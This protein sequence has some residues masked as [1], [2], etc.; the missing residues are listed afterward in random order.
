MSNYMRPIAVFFAFL[1]VIFFMLAPVVS[2]NQIAL[3]GYSSTESEIINGGVLM[4]I[5]AWPILPAIFGVMMGIFA[6]VLPGKIAAIIN[7]ISAFVPLFTFWFILGM[8]EF[9]LVGN[10]GRMVSYNPFSIGYGT[11]LSIICGVICAVLCFFP[12]FSAA[13]K[14]RTAGLGTD[15]GNEW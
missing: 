3:Y 5:C 15:V 14:T 6:M 8:D 9:K 7:G 4:L 11:I 1:Y 12:D 2:I 13:P 10:L